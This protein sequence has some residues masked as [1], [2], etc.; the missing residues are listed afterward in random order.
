LRGPGGGALG[1]KQKYATFLDGQQ[2]AT[3]SGDKIAERVAAMQLL[4]RTADQSRYRLLGL[5]PNFDTAVDVEEI[6]KMALEVIAALSAAVAKEHTTEA[7]Q[8]W[9]GLGAFHTLTESRVWKEVA[10]LGRVMRG[11]WGRYELGALSLRDFHRDGPFAVEVDVLVDYKFILAMTVA[12]QGLVTVLSAVLSADLEGFADAIIARLFEARFTLAST[13]QRRLYTSVNDAV[14]DAF[15][16]ARRSMKGPTGGEIRT[17]VD[18]RALFVHYL[19]LVA[20]TGLS[21]GAAANGVY[22][23]HRQALYHLDDPRGKAKDKAPAASATGEVKGSGG[24]GGTKKAGLVGG[25][26]SGPVCVSHLRGLLGLKGKSGRKSL[27]GELFKCTD[28]GCVREHVRLG[29]HTL[30]DLLARLKTQKIDFSSGFGR[31]VKE[32]LESCKGL[33]Q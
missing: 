16:E 31:E 5:L 9:W 26:A 6:K 3:N 13:N 10:V 24:A 32:A 29:D 25:G 33:H 19:G 30:A 14:T 18:V 4:V 17:A 8:A 21:E 27:G 15:D 2:L 20:F 11:E 12:L 1:A 23:A 7:V 28:S 22:A